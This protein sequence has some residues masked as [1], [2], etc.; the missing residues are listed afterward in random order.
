V[1]SLVSPFHYPR[2]LLVPLQTFTTHPWPPLQDSK[3][4]TWARHILVRTKRLALHSIA[5]ET[6]LRG[7]ACAWR[8]PLC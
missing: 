4:I 8:A 3:A 2:Q 1:F 5:T 6:A 7:T